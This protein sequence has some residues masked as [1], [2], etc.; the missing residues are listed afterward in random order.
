[1]AGLKTVVRIRLRAPGA[2]DGGR[3]ARPEELLGRSSGDLS[4]GRATSSRRSNIPCAGELDERTTFTV[5]AFSRAIEPGDYKLKLVLPA[6]GGRQVG[7]ATVELSV[8]EV[9]NRVLAPTSRRANPRRFPAAEAIVIADEAGARGVSAAGAS[10][11]KILPPSREAPIGLLRLEATCRP[12]D[13]E[14]RVLPRGQA[15]CS[16]L[17]A[18]LLRRDRSRRGPAQADDPRGRLRRL[19]QAHRRGRLGD[20][21]GERPAR[22]QDPAPARSR[23]RQGPH[24]GRRAVDRGGRREAGR[25]LS[26][27]QEAQ[28]LDERRALRGH[29]PD[30]R[31]LARR[32]PARDGD[33]RRRQGSQR[34]PDAEGPE[35]DDRERARR[36]RAAP[37]LRDRQEQPFRE[38]PRRERTS[39]SRR[40]GGRRRSRA[41]RSPRSCR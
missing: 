3:Q 30:V 24:Q 9:G 33:R 39:P 12:P 1:M 15:P 14:G 17:A 34:P 13:H 10:K 31:V 32:L 19:R 16:P 35:H 21:P 4:E 40:T 18:A 26:R 23:G 28:G 2:L 41:S 8:P 37:H 22:R 20:Q 36:R 7:E 6:P 27:R 5:R 29:D 25:A 38:R 11:L